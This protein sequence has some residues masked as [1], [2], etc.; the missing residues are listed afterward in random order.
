MSAHYDNA[1]DGD[2]TYGTEHEVTHQA[3]IFRKGSASDPFKN[4]HCLVPSAERRDWLVS[5]SE[6][7]SVNPQLIDLL[8]SLLNRERFQ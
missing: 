2:W 6:W 4:P 5:T 8:C 3:V 7:A 1:K